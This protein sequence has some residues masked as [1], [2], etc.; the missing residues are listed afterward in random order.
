LN[1]FYQ[2]TTKSATGIFPKKNLGSNQGCLGAAAS[3]S[4]PDKVGVL[5]VLFIM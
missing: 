5:H 2:I 4:G 1:K 3:S